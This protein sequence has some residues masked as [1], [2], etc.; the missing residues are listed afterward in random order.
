MF[1][2]DN[3]Q[4]LGVD[5]QV[6]TVDPGHAAF[7]TNFS[8]WDIYR[9][10]AQLEAL[11]RSGAASDA[12]QSMV[13]DYAQGGTLPKWIEN[14]SETYFMVGDPADP[15]LADY[16][17]FGAR[18]FDTGAALADMV[19]EATKTSTIRPG[20]HYLDAARLPARDGGYGCCNYYGPVSTTLEYDTADFAISALA[21]ALGNTADQRPVR[22][23]GPRTGA[24]C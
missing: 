8:G 7:Y 15:I 24:T 2:D 17:A 13:D 3:R 23:T 1:S 20:L 14:N 9:A 5:G 4:Y 16:Y 11:R 19:A 10:Q 21:G 22:R 18:H 6:H 12:A